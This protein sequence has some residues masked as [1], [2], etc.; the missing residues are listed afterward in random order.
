VKATALAPLAQAIE[1]AIDVLLGIGIGVMVVALVWQVIGRY[2][3]GHAPGWSEELARYL[4][5]WITM[6]G[7]AAALRGGGHLSVTSLVDVLGPRALAVVL[8]LR[9]A[10][11]VAACGLLAWQG[12]LFAQL[13]GVQESAAMEIP[14]SLPYAAL[15]VGAALI[16]VMVLLARLLGR[17]FA[18]QPGSAEEGVF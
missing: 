13:N 14:M 10:V 1:R 16:V 6:L 3:F 15:P 4:M 2:V 9:D 17:P 7:S 5:L 11:M 12:L 18:T 8:A